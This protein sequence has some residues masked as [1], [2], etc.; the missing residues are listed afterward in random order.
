[1]APVDIDEDYYKILEVSET[2]SMADI[3]ASYRR[4][5]NSSHPDWGRDNSDATVEFQLVRFLLLAI[6]P[7]CT[8]LTS[9][10][11]TTVPA[12]QCCI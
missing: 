1:M 6:L 11:P 3:I 4:L 10:C 2:A 9:V 8:K 5:A 7:L 12:A